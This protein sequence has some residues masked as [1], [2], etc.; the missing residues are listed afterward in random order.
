MSRTGLVGG[1]YSRAEDLDGFYK[2][3]DVSAGF[4]FAQVNRG[5]GAT[6]E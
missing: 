2:L 6:L 1:E 3:V 4:N 5:N